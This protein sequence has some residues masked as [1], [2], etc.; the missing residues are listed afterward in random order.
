MDVFTCS[1][2]LASEESI[3]QCLQTVV[4]QYGAID[5]LV[6]N[7]G[8]VETARAVDLELDSWNRVTGVNLEG[9][10]LMAREFGKA[11]DSG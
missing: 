6:N 2:D 7:A 10:W 5:I 11:T 9:A 3:E 1:L 4:D 8:I